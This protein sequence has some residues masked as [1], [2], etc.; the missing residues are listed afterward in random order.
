LFCCQHQ[1]EHF[2]HA[3]S[4]S[5]LVADLR[6]MVLEYIYTSVG[7]KRGSLASL[8]SLFASF[9][10]WYTEE[11]KARKGTMLMYLDK[12]KA[13]EGELHQAGIAEF[14]PCT[15]EQISRLEDW[16][17]RPLPQAYREF[18]F[19]MGRWGGGFWIGSDCFYGDLKDIQEWARDLLQENGFPGMLPDDAFVVW[20]H[21]G[22]QFYF[23]YC[24]EGEDPPVYYYLEDETI[25]TSFHCE[26][27]HFSDFLAKAI[28]GEIDG[29][30]YNAHLIAKTEISHPERAKAMQESEMRKKAIFKWGGK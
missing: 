6:E 9:I 22:Y 24:H 30:H 17:G 11:E 21:Q 26:Y 2:L 29:L 20:M 7:E 15:E 25:K 3:A 13:K 16:Y 10:L 18:L 4:L 19:W 5:Q 28:D 23:F 27:L 14:V 1:R 8:E 12:A